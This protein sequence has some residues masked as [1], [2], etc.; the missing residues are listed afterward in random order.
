MAPACLCVL[1]TFVAW[2][3]NDLFQPAYT[4]DIGSFATLTARLAYTM[5]SSSPR[6]REV[7]DGK[8]FCSIF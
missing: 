6:R 5:S 4:C 7:S 3:S 2:F 1:V 8:L